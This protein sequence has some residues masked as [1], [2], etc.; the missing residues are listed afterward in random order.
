[1]YWRE[2][3]LGRR[4]GCATPAVWGFGAR[5][6][7]LYT[8]GVTYIKLYPPGIGDHPENR[9]T[10]ANPL[11]DRID[12]IDCDVFGNCRGLFLPDCLY[13]TEHIFLTNFAQLCTFWPVGQVCRRELH[14]KNSDSPRSPR[15]AAWS[16]QVYCSP[17]DGSE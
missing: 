6:F 11:C 7:V 5:L 10:Q 15:G 9:R 4:Y 3:I 13:F 17:M 14:E 16:I 8:N 2:K 12:F 1:M